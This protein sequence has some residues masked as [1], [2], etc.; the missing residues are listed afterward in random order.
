MWQRGLRAEARSS[1][2]LLPTHVHGGR[3]QRRYIGEGSDLAG[4]R[5]RQLRET[6]CRRA[7]EY[8]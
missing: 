8:G 5:G 6:V 1:A 4:A 7:Q 2:A 3:N